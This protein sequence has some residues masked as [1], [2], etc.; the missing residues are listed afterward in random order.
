MSQSAKS[1]FT[2]IRQYF[3]LGYIRHYYNAA[4]HPHPLRFIVFFI[5]TA[6]LVFSLAI[7]S[8]FAIINDTFQGDRM[9]IYGLTS[10]MYLI[11]FSIL[12]TIVLW[13]QGYRHRGQIIASDIPDNLPKN[14]PYE[15]WVVLLILSLYQIINKIFEW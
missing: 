10:F 11:G 2:R 3:Y 6:C 12:P 7:L 5:V 15:V 13:I 4:K 9:V 8:T 1:F 14:S